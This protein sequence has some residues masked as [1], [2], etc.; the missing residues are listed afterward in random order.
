[1]SIE[2]GHNIVQRNTLF[3]LASI[4]AIIAA[5]VWFSATDD[6]DHSQHGSSENGIKVPT[7]SHA[8]RQGEAIFNANCVV[9]HGKN[10]AGTQNG[11]HLIHKIYEP[12]HHS[13][14]SFQRAVKFGVRAHHWPF[15]NMPPVPSVTDA[16]V[17]Q[18]TAYVRE[19]QRA[20]GIR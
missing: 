11:P 10:G 14:L 4:A 8:A 16:D 7:L 13:D 19:L 17:T 6:H 1:M 9:C 2:T 5:T 15:G 18:I 12:S 3:A 20:N